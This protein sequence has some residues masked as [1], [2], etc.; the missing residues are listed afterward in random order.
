MVRRLSVQGSA[1]RGKSASRAAQVAYKRCHSSPTPTHTRVHL[2]WWGISTARDKIMTVRW[3]R[4]RWMRVWRLRRKCEAPR[5]RD[6]APPATHKGLGEAAALDLSSSGRGGGRERPARDTAQPRH[7]DSASSRLPAGPASWCWPRGPHRPRPRFARD[8]NAPPEWLGF[9][10]ASRW[11]P[12][13]L[14]VCTSVPQEE[15]PQPFEHLMQRIAR[16]PKSQQF[17][18]LMGKRDAGEMGSHPSLCLFWQ[19]ARSA[20]SFS[21]H[22]VS[23][24][25]WVETSSLKGV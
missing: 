13:R 23:L 18:G 21:D 7:G 16:R 25:L 20:R 5:A 19:P 4:G 11:L 6:T 8:W 15:L 24:A 17:F 22:P 14:F 2:G 1:P 10:G 12:I 3:L 9:P